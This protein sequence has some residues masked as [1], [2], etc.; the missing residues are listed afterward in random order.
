VS[1]RVIPFRNPRAPLRGA[2]REAVLAHYRE[3]VKGVAFEAVFRAFETSTRDFKNVACEELIP[4]F[5]EAMR[6]ELARSGY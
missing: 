3:C 6:R 1:A 2:A 4:L 5:V